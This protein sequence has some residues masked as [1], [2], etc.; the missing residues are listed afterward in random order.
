[1]EV[2]GDSVARGT[3][4]ITLHLLLPSLLPENLPRALEEY[5]WAR[6]ARMTVCDELSKLSRAVL[7]L[8]P[9]HIY[10]YFV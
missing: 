6:N 8:P 3:S 4:L 2:S 7:P 5:I 10:I 1:M 9:T